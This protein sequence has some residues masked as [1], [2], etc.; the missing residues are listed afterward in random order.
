MALLK[1]ALTTELIVNSS[2]YI[3]DG[4]GGMREQLERTIM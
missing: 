1:N 3:F 2:S 4:S